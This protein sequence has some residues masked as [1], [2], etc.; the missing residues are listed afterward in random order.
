MA[1]YP[2]FVSEFYSHAGIKWKIE[3]CSTSSMVVTP[4]E[5]NVIG[6]GF[7]L[8][9]NG[10]RERYDFIMGSE[11]KFT[12]LVEESN[13][14]DLEE[15]ISLMAYGVEGIYFV[16]LYKWVT[17]AYVFY[18]GGHMMPDLGRREDIYYPYEL[19][20]SF[21]DGLGTLKDM[22]FWNA[23]ALY[24]GWESFH[25]ILLKMFDKTGNLTW[26]SGDNYLTTCVHYYDTNHN[27][28]T[29]QDPLLYSRVDHAA[30]YKWEDDTNKPM[31]CYD[32]L[33]QI[34]EAFGVRIFL[35][36]GMWHVIQ[37]NEMINTGQWIRYYKYGSSTVYY[38]YNAN[39]RAAAPTWLT[40]GY[41]SY[42]APLKKISKYY[43][44]KQSP[45][46][47]NL[48]PVQT[49]Y[50]T[51]VN[52][53]NGIS[54][55]N[56]ETLNFGG[57]VNETFTLTDPYVAPFMVKYVMKVIITLADTTK[58]YLTNGINGEGA[59]TWST[60]SSKTVI[61]W[62]M[63]THQGSYMQEL[64]T[65]G[66]YTPVIPANASGTFELDFAGFY[67]LDYTPLVSPG[68]TMT[69]ICQNF[70]LSQV[71]A[72]NVATEGTVYFFTNNNNQNT[73]KDYEFKKAI[74]GDGP[75][76]YSLGRIQTYNSVSWVNSS[77]WGI[78]NAVKNTKLHQLMINEI[79]LG[80]QTPCPLY[81]GDMVS[82]DYNP[83]K[84]ILRSEGVF[85]ALSV[86]YSAKSDTW[87]GTWFMLNFIESDAQS[88]G[89]FIEGVE[90]TS[91]WYLQSWTQEEVVADEEQFI[92][93][94]IK[95]D[96]G[97]VANEVAK[98]T[99]QVASINDSQ[100]FVKTDTEY[101]VDDVVTSISTPAFTKTLLTGDIIQ[102]VN[103][104]NGER[105]NLTVDDDY[106][107][108]GTD[109]AVQSYTFLSDFP[110][111]SYL[112][113]KESTKCADGLVLVIATDDY[114]VTAGDMRIIMSAAT[115]TKYITIFSGAEYVGSIINCINN[116][117]DG[118]Q[119]IIESDAGKFING[120]SPYVLSIR[121][122]QVKLIYN[123][124]EWVT[125]G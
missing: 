78:K 14:G 4:V 44:Y 116:I 10:L 46:G 32:V 115:N 53:L 89:L 17:N 102:L 3:V 85:Y 59:Y 37:P 94:A 75:N 90:D 109:I 12:M 50:T 122:D 62:S 98:I 112:Q 110:A 74:I 20:L 77:G 114:N 97:F 80:Q 43:E 41:H 121:Y 54:G 66:F 38:N 51:Q 117:A 111:G 31:K 15:F 39:F 69:Y 125:C 67:D 101:L 21:T 72:N 68:I 13:A 104:V 9:Y 58:R 52:W 79:I 108:G 71:L 42:I 29:N 70:V 2:W 56:N 86:T 25:G 35:A 23:G 92:P 11:L 65:W 93:V 95:D 61:L 100:S 48:L 5:V 26:G 113:L 105:V 28:H 96:G 106:I 22:D 55:G 103:V 1:L 49:S 84:T 6:D 34:C 120:N 19:E 118:N 124:T 73:T 91:T 40:G 83:S 30:F 47:T 27:V 63:V 64:T 123:G 82:T 33:R 36:N 8:S 76:P 107:G 88:G 18:W 119:T 24:T 60:N 81:T 45:A 99:T 7:N 16:R 57:T 87:S